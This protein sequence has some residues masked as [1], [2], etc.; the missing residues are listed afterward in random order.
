MLQQI[1]IAGSGGQGIQFAG[2]LLARAGVR[3]GLQA[4]YVPAYGAERR[5]GPSF[6][7]VV[8]ADREIY[9]PVF[10]L[11]DVLLALDQRGRNQYGPTLKAT[12]FILANRDLAAAVA[13]GEAGTVI[14]LPASS[15]AAQICPQ[16]AANLV[17]LG[18][19]AAITGVVRTENLQAEL[20]I[21]SAKKPQLLETNL[22]ALAEGFS[23]GMG[24][25]A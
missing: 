23:W 4:T 6:C 7:S 19:Y 11:A 9:A 16:G 22:Q 17:T 24:R 25:A 13:P 10:K 18:A 14:E 21:I 1:V 12:G 2:Q 20:E 3:Q 15:L 5:G 8:L